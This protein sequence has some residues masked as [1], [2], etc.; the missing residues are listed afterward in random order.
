MSY[1]KNDQYKV[2]ED[3]SIHRVFF[4]NN[5]F[6]MWIHDLDSH[7]FIGVNEAALKE[8]GYSREEFLKMTIHDIHPAEDLEHIDRSVLSTGDAS[9]VHRHRLKN[10][11]EITVATTS[12]EVEYDGHRALFTIIRDLEERNH[13]KGRKDENE[14]TSRDLIQA[15]PV[16]YYRSTLNGFFL[17]VNPAFAKLLGFSREE[18]LSI[19]IPDAV[20]FTS[21]EPN[22]KEM[23]QNFPSRPEIYQVRRKDGAEIWVEDFSRYVQDEEG[24]V[25]Y[26]EGVCREI[27]DREA[28]KQKLVENEEQYRLLVDQLPVAIVVHT[29]LSL[30]Y[31]NLA[32][33]KLSAADSI[34]QLFGMSIIEFVHPDSQ[35]LALDHIGAISNG[36]KKL[37]TGEFKFIRVDGSRAVVQITS[38]P[39]IFLG[40]PSIQSV[41][42]DISKQKEIEERVLLQSAA[43]NAVTNAI[44]ITDQ[45]GRIEWVNPGYEKLTG[46]SAFQAIGSDIGKLS[47]S[48]KQ[49]KAFYKDLWDTILSGKEWH[50]QLTN[51]RKDG[52]LYSEGMTITPTLNDEGAISHFIVV[53]EDTTERK[54][55]EEELTQ[56]Q[57]LDVIGRLA[58]GVAHDYNNVLGVILGYG[59]LIKSKLHDEE[60]ISHQLDA[61]ISAAKRGAGLTKRLLSFARREIIS[62][63]VISVNSSIESIKEMMQQIIGENRELVFNLEKD[64]WNVKVDPPQLDQILVNLATNAR[65]AI[66]NVGTITIDTS[67]IH[68]DEEFVRDHTEFMPGEY[69]KISFTDTGKG[70]DKD[71]V[72]KIFEPFFTTKP[73]GQGTGLGLAMVYAIVKQ[74]G[75]N[76]EVKSEPGV[77]TTFDI[78]FPRSYGEL[79]N[80]GEQFL[81]GMTKGNATVLVVEDRADLLEFAKRT[82][83]QYGYKVL[84]A[85]SPQEAILLCNAF[86]EDIDLLLADVIMPSMNGGELSRRIRKIKP[87][88]RTLFMSGFTEDVLIPPGVLGEGIPFIQKPF[89][90]QALAIKVHEVIDNK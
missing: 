44:A 39:I 66:E 58:G 61:I 60:S 19:D 28:A 78:Y 69:I 10:G 89:T 31:A 45:K 67:N 38:T 36:T 25:I 41:I 80:I 84:A 86:S 70:I 23:S 62:P 18:L 71:T 88:I 27:T 79:D 32:M 46:Y 22:V 90:P 4:E 14:E 85:L 72:K 48:G 75:G 24:D 13:I 56:A 43:L 34:A 51:R 20:H 68:A 57:K 55:L 73:F 82:L 7:K 40:R 3:D 16:G 11:D 8:Y 52:T 29:D 74:N 26:R 33:L 21:N 37:H 15:M 47:K 42:Q 30:V 1:I 64:L 49:D 59:E 9:N 5:P 6:P 35:S 65:D 50:G 63:K 81:S 87:G 12:H 77:G 17:Q 2:F 76:I 53:K 83:E 54:S